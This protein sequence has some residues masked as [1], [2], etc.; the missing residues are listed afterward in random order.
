MTHLVRSEPW[1]IIDL[2]PTKGHV[3]VRQDWRYVW[4]SRPD[5]PPWTPSE[6]HAYHHAVDHLIWAHWSLRARVFVKARATGS[7]NPVGTELASRFGQLGMTLSFDVRSMQGPSHWRA[8]VTKVDPQKR[9][10]PQASCAFELRQL[11]LF[12]TDVLPH[13]AQ[14]FRGT[15]P[16]AQRNFSVTA[17]EFGHALGYGYSRGKGEENKPGHRYYDDV[18]SIMNIGRHVR[19]RHFFLITET[20]HR[21]VPSCS[22]NVVVES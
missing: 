7:Q 14:R 12:N 1:G 8:T 5:V 20:L 4:E 15:D 18:H 16:R 17:H 21:M 2:D 3:F 11:T 9:P 13:V 19:A 6:K 10:H 22:F